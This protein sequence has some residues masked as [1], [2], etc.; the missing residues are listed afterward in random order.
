LALLV[1]SLKSSGLCFSLR[2]LLVI[3]TSGFLL[4][5]WTHCSVL[6]VKSGLCFLPLVSSGSVYVWRLYSPG[7]WDSLLSV[8]SCLYSGSNP[9]LPNKS[10][11]PHSP[12]QAHPRSSGNCCPGNYQRLSAPQGNP[13]SPRS[14]TQKHR[15]T[16]WNYHHPPMFTTPFPSHNYGNLFQMPV[17]LFLVGIVATRILSSLKAIGNT[18]KES[19]MNTH[20]VVVGNTLFA[21]KDLVAH[22]L[23]GFPVVFW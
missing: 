8:T 6:L 23:N 4:A 5:L 2:F 20:V 16:L 9:G 17:I 15:R 10:P 1:F 22:M 12:S 21:G 18:S 19:S 7:Y 3:V 11:P 14:L 13:R